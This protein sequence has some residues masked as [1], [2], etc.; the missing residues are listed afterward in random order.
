MVCLF[1]LRVDGYSIFELNNCGIVLVTEKVSNTLIV[2]SLGR[3]G[4]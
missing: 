3:R 1:K 2:N 4:F